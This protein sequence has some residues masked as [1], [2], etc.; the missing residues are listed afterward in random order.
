MSTRLGVLLALLLMLVPFPAF[1]QSAEDIEKAQQHFARGAEKYAGGEYAKAVA[2][3]MS[4]H[5]ITPNAMFLY[6]VSLC[7]ERLGNLEDALAA[8]RR[9]L[10]HDGMPPDVAVRNTARIHAF[11]TILT[12]QDVGQRAAAQAKAG[13]GEIKGSE[14]DVVVKTTTQSD[15]ITT[16]GWAGA[17]LVAVGGGLLIGG[18]VTNGSIVRDIETYEDAA[19]RG[20]R[21]EYNDLNE[22][23]G[24]KQT[25]GKILYGVGI[26]TAGIGAALFLVDL[27]TGTEEVPVAAIA[28]I[29][30]GAMVSA[31]LRF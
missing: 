25:T 1:A 31:M 8:S 11:R 3:F 13:G 14:G 9:A 15:G 4:G 19:R 5:A 12:T 10:Q 26:G 17:A 29:R 16:M 24:K 23:I 6:N 7:Y 18:V 27:L 2:E 21:G 22:R 30:G 28:P 20:D